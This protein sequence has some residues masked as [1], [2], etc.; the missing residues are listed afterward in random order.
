MAIVGGAN[1]CLYATV[2]LKFARLGVLSKDGFCKVFDQKADG[3]VRSESN[4]F[5]ILQ[6]AKDARRIYCK[7]VHS[8]VNSDGYKEE[9]ITFPSGLLQQALM[10]QCYQEAK[11]S[12]SNFFILFFLIKENFKLN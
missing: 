6:R 1:L 2:S 10:E 7:V 3:Y 5:V 9:G 12:L 8:R 11:V 4:V